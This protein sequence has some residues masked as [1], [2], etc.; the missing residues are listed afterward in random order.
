MGQII[1]PN[2]NSGRGIF[3]CGR[4][5]FRISMTIDLHVWSSIAGVRQQK[6]VLV[7]GTKSVGYLEWRFAGISSFFCPFSFLSISSLSRELSNAWLMLILFRHDKTCRWLWTLAML[8]YNERGVFAV[9]NCQAHAFNRSR[10]FEKVHVFTGRIG[11]RSTDIFGGP[12]EWNCMAKM[13]KS[14]F[15]Q[16]VRHSFKSSFPDS[17][18]LCLSPLF[19]HELQH[20][21]SRLIGDQSS[22]KCCRGRRSGKVLPSAVPSTRKR[23]DNTQ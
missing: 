16:I 13:M 21:C 8:A 19:Y 9:G 6:A 15:G 12:V 23:Y 4:D 11:S 10:A 22:L 5:L 17:R 14:G 20:Y 7:G 2:I 3:T 1:S 18:D